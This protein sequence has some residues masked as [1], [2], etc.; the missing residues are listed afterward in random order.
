[1]RAYQLASSVTG[2]L[3]IRPTLSFEA[4]V[5]VLGK[6]LGITFE[7]DQEGKYEEYPAYRAFVLGLEVALL[8]PPVPEFDTRNEP[9]DCFQ[10]VIDTLAYVEDKGVGVDLSALVEAQLLA[11][12]KLELER[13]D[14]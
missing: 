12:T 7:P 8:A 2:C 5:A 3:N 10:L 9:L 4:T 14:E 11:C 1:M 6:A 13:I